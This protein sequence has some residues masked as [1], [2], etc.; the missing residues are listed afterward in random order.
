[1]IRTWDVVAA[2]PG[3]AP[4]S[5]GQ[6]LP[7]TRIHVLD[8]TGTP[9]ET[10]AAGEV[11][12][13][14]D[15]GTLGYLDEYEDSPFIDDPGGQYAGAYRTG[16][17]GW[18]AADGT[19]TVSGRLDDQVQ[20]LGVRVE[21]GEVAAVLATAPGVERAVVVA[22][23]DSRTGHH[24]IAFVRVQPGQTPDESA[25]S[26]YLRD[27]VLGPTIPRR[28]S[29]VD[30]FPLTANGKIDKQALLEQIA[31]DAPT[32]GR[33][34]STPEHIDRIPDHQKRDLAARLRER[35]GVASPAAEV[36]RNAPLSFAQER[37]WFLDKLFPER[38]NYHIPRTHHVL[39]PL[40]ADALRAAV[41]LIQDRHEVL[42]TGYT[43]VDGEP[44]QV[45]YAPSPAV[46]DV[47]D[48]SGHKRDEA[49]IQQAV[50]EFTQKPF[51]LVNGP[52]WRTQL[53]RLSDDEHILTVVTHHIASD[54]WSMPPLYIE[55]AA[56]YAAFVNG[57]PV[58][59]APLPVQYAEYALRQRQ[60][61]E[62][63]GFEDDLAYWESELSGAP[64]LLTVPGARPRPPTPSHTGARIR[65][66]FEHASSERLRQL[67]VNHTATPFMIGLALFQGYL[68]RLTGQSDLVVGI[69][70]ADRISGDL[71]ESIGFF[72]NSLAMR[73][74]V[75]AGMTF[76]QLAKRVRDSSVRSYDRREVPF[77]HRFAVF[78]RHVD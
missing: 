73:T 23:P 1:M 57:E 61:H 75:D 53:I 76:D 67:A 14:T 28:F 69:P 15:V 31:A 55:L 8:E 71:H 42:R 66:Q 9:T 77:E 78:E 52:A 32:A 62:D 35:L 48:F 17:R 50:A 38:S 54:G 74:R 16:D 26:A 40:D 30:A 3:E 4:L 59:L 18:L 10:G 70:S 25:W 5:V 46:F 65:F 20:I 44:V 64:E 12:I 33:A 68:S 22:V 47:M 34:A 27:R 21:P 29:V 11:V 39:G 51:D 2:D 63:G 45:V 60:T 56:A 6:A 43:E 49:I 36:V 7:Y 19:L 37:L 24:L 72:V 41:D 58:S 13:A